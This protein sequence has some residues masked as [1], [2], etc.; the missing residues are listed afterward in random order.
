MIDH[1]VTNVTVRTPT[2]DSS[3]PFKLNSVFQ[4]RAKVIWQTGEI[5]WANAKGLQLQDPQVL[6]D[7]AK[8]CNLQQHPDFSWTQPHIDN[9]IAHKKALIL[10]AKSHQGPQFKFGVQLPKNSKHASALDN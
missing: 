4:V 6:I 8:A 3:C 10:A 7:Y 5:S 2:K 1:K 9:E